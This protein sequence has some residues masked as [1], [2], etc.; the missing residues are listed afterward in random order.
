MPASA[1]CKTCTY[2]D[3]I[4]ASTYGRCRFDVPIVSDVA[5]A[6]QMTQ[7]ETGPKAQWPV[8]KDTDWCGHWVKIP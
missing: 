6:Y 4:P 1:P 3:P 2:Y 8:C 5:G 7:F